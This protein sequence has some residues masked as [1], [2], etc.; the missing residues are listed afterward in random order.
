MVGCC[1][2]GKKTLGLIK[3][4]KLADYLSDY[5]RLNDI[6]PYE[7]STSSVRN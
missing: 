2:R 1:K 7:R 5:Q 3:G 6:A 4:G